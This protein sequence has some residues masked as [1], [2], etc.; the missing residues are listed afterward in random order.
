MRKLAICVALGLACALPAYGL[1]QQPATREI[2][3]PAGSLVAALDALAHQTGAQF[4]YSTSQL[5]GL[6]TKG[7]HGSLDARAA[8]DKL[9][10]GTGYRAERDASGAMV[11][12]RQPVPA[13]K[14]APPPASRTPATG[15][16]TTGAPTKTM[17]EIVVTGSRIPRTVVEGP[18]PVV[19]ISAQDI[20]E[21]GFINVPDL[22]ASLNQNLGAL[23]NNQYTDGF[24]PGAQAVD[25]RGLGPGHT[26]VLVNGRRIADY[27][28]AYNGSSNFTDISNIPVALIDRVEIL[29]GSASAVYGS[30]AIAGVTNFILKKKADGTTIDFRAGGAE[31]G[32]YASQQLDITTGFSKGKLDTIFGLEL[33]NRNPLWAYQRSYTDSRLDSPA[34]RTDIVAS[35]NFYRSDIDG[36]YLDPGQATCAKIGYL[37]QGSMQYASRDGYAADGGPGYFCGSYDDVRYGTFENGR[38]MANLYAGATYHFNGFTDAYANVLAS[39]SH[40]YSFNTLLEW[41]NC[42]PLNGDCTDTPFFNTATG[43]VEE[44]GRDYFTLEEN[45]NLQRGQI[46]NIGNALSLNVGI[47]GTFGAGSDWNYEAN[48]GHSQN[49]VEEKWPALVAAKAQALYL[50]PSLG[51]DP[52]S[53][54]QMYDAPVQR[55]YTPL[56]PAQFASISQ[57]SIDH[58]K[59]RTENYT[60]TLTNTNLFHLPA[61][62]VGFAGVAEYGNS[63]FSQDADPLS[64]DG[65]Y[66]GLH[67]TS[68]IGSRSRMALGYEFS[69]PV[70]SRLTLTTAGRYD[71]YSYSDTDS[72]KFTYAFGVEYRPFKSLLLR[73]SL[74]TGFR[75][76]DLNYLY[77]G[78]SG[79][80][81]DG[82]DY[83]QCRLLEPQS[84]PDYYDNCSNGDVSFNGRSH[85]STALKDET[86]RSFTY[87]LV[88]APTPSFDV[89]ADYYHIKLS[90]EVEFQDSD[91]ILREEANCRLGQAPD[92]SPVDGTSA[93]C[94][95]IESQVVRN[96]ATAAFNPNAITSVLV[97]PINAAI[98]ETSGVDVNVHYRLATARA[99][100]FDFRAGATYVA[101]HRTQLSADSEVDNELTDLF[102]YLIPRTKANASVTWNFHDFTATLY[103]SRLGGLPNFD[104]TERMAPTF[105]YNLTMGYHVAPGVD[106]SFV[107]DNLFD[108]RPQRDP[109]WT[110][111]PYFDR[112]WFNPIGRAYFVDVAVKLGAHNH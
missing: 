18:A 103:G 45:G 83:Y 66:Y 57:D 106:V 71:R 15:T 55:L 56:T 84:G 94:R 24:T 89:S 25:L 39:T 67:N 23:Q 88:Y 62:P 65:S 82:T 74:S 78:M 95:Q 52:D 1:A 32:G 75:A 104:G 49:R 86:S 64:L 21:R 50:G 80:S 91:T 14:P 112:A 19:R 4:V 29:S 11:I 13:T 102:T 87:G 36:N 93:F 9:L 2:N 7:V 81:S 37:D 69:V 109:T 8:L 33:L 98:D 17:Q 12:V 58:D 10:A 30:D 44:W 97:L 79:S 35:R 72:G 105:L 41:F 110:S 90:N 53:G 107:V 54:Y 22:M 70:F 85:G 73:G 77:E 28:Q 47:K 59:S 40:Q 68:A 63:Y 42:E 48:F 34:D 6:T 5:S 76:P 26:L 43:Q 99:G 38:R 92:G 16:T 111:Y 46:R 60:F 100:N 31:H 61:G 27:P 96:P 3:I 20:K 108:K 51:T 101:M